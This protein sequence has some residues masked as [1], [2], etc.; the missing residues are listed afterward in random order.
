MNTMKKA[1]KNVSNSN[2]VTEF[3]AVSGLLAIAGAMVMIATYVASC[4][5]VG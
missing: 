2:A 5:V 3:R 4:A 1:I